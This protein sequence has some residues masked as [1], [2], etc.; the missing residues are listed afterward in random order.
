MLFFL[1]CTRFEILKHK[2]QKDHRKDFT[3]YFRTSTTQRH[4]IKTK[5]RTNFDFETSY[6]RNNKSRSFYNSSTEKMDNG[7]KRVS[8]L[9]NSNCDKNENGKYESIIL[10]ESTDEIITA[11]PGPDAVSMGKVQ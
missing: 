8:E 6:D 11:G 9:E 4:K 7:T 1:V 5:V 2:K 10:V 3:V